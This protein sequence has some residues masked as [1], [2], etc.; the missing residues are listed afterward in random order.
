M[1]NLKMFILYPCSKKEY[2]EYKTQP[3]SKVHSKL[4]LFYNLL[5]NNVIIGRYLLKYLLKEFNDRDYN[6]DYDVL[7]VYKENVNKVKLSYVEDK[8]KKCDYVLL[9]NFMNNYECERDYIK[10]MKK[11]LAD[12]YGDKFQVVKLNTRSMRLIMPKIAIR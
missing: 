3:A 5:Y 8:M 1:A 2:D 11:D 9:F 4:S 7:C 6:L 12:K 10:D